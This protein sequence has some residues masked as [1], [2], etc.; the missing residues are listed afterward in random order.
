M[1]Q[2]E[3]ERERERGMS[4]ENE[5]R[6]RILAIVKAWDRSSSHHRR[7][8]A[9]ARIEGICDIPVPEPASR[10]AFLVRFW[11]PSKVGRHHVMQRPRPEQRTPCS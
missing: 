7:C 5:E 6:H 9:L 8:P 10:V 1:V 4:A 3:R 2:R 11:L